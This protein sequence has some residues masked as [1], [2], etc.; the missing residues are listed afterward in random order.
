MYTPPEKEDPRLE[1]I[2][3]PPWKVALAISILF[4]AT[5]F[6]AIQLGMML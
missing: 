4:A 6:C 3:V 5:L 1:H 2:Y